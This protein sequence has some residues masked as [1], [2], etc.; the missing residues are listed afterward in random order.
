MTRVLVVDDDPAVL[1]AH[2]RALQL[3]GFEVDTADDGE[4]AI[5]RL[6]A[7]YDCV[8]SDLQMPRLD[9]VALL[10]RVR[11]H[12]LDV[13]VILVTGAPSVESAIDAVEQGAFR[14]LTKPV[15][16]TELIATVTAAA[17]LC[18]LARAKRLAFRI[19]GND[20][21]VGDRAGLDA[22]FARALGSLWMAFQPIVSI[23][24]R[25]VFAHEALMRSDEPALPHPGAVLE[26]AERLGTVH[27][28]GRVV[29]ARVAAAIAQAPED[30]SIFV[31]LH[32]RDLVDDELL[33]GPL[34]EV[35]RRVV[36]EITERASLHDLG[37]LRA[38]VARLRAAGFRLAVDDL[39]A[40]YAGLTTFATI[41]PEIVKID[42]SLVRDIDTSAV[43]RQVVA[44][45]TQLSH[46][47]G[48][49][50]VAEGVETPAERAALVEVGCDLLQGYLFARPGRPFPGV[51][52]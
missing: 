41:E 38:R 46:D 29:R 45:M 2:R 22:T 12:D 42:M 14:Y 6:A 28:V 31:N 10:G 48:I 24:A 49:Q 33:D 36:L 11:E 8:L 23:Q 17:R 52:F 27:A 37:D 15:S 40:G 9:G 39:G 7:G 1:A 47:L 34:V 20:Q 19:T 18:A 35:A 3:A 30:V 44:R 26:A 51:S 13:P 32:P 5:A 25:R 16:M 43:K 21:L 50:V 4:R